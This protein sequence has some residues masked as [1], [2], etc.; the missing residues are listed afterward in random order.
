MWLT[1]SHS[2]RKS[3]PIGPNPMKDEIF[4]VKYTPL[5]DISNFPASTRRRFDVHPTSITVK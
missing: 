5:R 3:H 4:H 2:L 1:L